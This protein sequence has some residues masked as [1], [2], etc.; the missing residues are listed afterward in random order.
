MARRFSPSGRRLARRTWKPHARW[1]WR[2]E[3]PPAKPPPGWEEVPGSDA[4][5]QGEVSRCL[6]AQADWP[7]A[8]A[9]LIESALKRSGFRSWRCW[10][11]GHSSLACTSQ[12]NG[13]SLSCKGPP[14]PRDIKQAGRAGGSLDQ[15]QK[16]SSTPPGPL[17]RSK[18]ELGW[19]LT[20]AQG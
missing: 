9:I 3:A 11:N 2:G 7:V 15:R 13:L 19:R 8:A 16:S 1:N 17:V 4:D 10:M 20:L 18:L 12:P 14:E 5:T 6:L